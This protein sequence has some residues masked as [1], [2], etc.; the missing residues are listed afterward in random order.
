MYRYQHPVVPAPD[1]HP[2]ETFTR[3][4]EEVGKTMSLQHC[5]KSRKVGNNL[6]TH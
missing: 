3:E 4:Y 5:L 2:G 1:V 6:N